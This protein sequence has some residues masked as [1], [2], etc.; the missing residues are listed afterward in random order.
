MH[1]QK[2]GTRSLSGNSD[3]I[4]NASHC[5]SSSLGPNGPWSTK[6]EQ[7]HR[8]IK[9]HR[10]RAAEYHHLNINAVN[11]SLRC[12]GRL[13]KGKEANYKAE[14]IHKYHVLLKLTLCISR[15]V[16]SLQCSLQRG[17]GFVTHK[18][19]HILY[20]THTAPCIMLDREGNK[21]LLIHAHLHTRTP[22][23]CHFPLSPLHVYCQPHEGYRV[24]GLKSYAVLLHSNVLL[25]T[26]ELS[27]RLLSK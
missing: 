16:V 24:I 2:V 9:R 15:D 18:Y 14:G 19:L 3:G 5:A 10:V 17:A 7:V 12:E 22:Q 26:A 4:C 8:Q 23:N 13:Q 20:C 11:S 25:C 6:A 1:S 27:F 21:Q